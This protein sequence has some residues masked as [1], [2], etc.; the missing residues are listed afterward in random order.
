LSPASNLRTSFL[1]RAFRGRPD[2]SSG[3]FRDPLSQ[4]DFPSVGSLAIRLKMFRTDE[5]AEFQNATRNRAKKTS[6]RSVPGAL[7]GSRITSADHADN[8][9]GREGHQWKLLLIQIFTHALIFGCLR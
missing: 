3:P 4:P 2:S 9:Y 1:G 5:T 6:A 7:P 8:D